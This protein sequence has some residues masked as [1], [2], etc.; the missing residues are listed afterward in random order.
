MDRVLSGDVVA[1]LANAQTEAAV[2]VAFGE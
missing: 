2:W 1:P